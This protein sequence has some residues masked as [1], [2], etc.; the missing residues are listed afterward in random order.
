METDSKEESLSDSEMME[1]FSDFPTGK[2]QVK[3]PKTKKDESL[4]HLLK[5]PVRLK[6]QNK[7][8]KKKEDKPKKPRG[9]PKVWTDEKIAQRKAENKEAAKVRREQKK[10][11]EKLTKISLNQGF[12]EAE[13]FRVARRAIKTKKQ[14]E[15]ELVS[16]RE[17]QQ[18]LDKSLIFTRDECFHIDKFSYYNKEGEI[19]SA[20]ERCSRQKIWQPRDWEK[21]MIQL[22]RESK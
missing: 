22:K 3:D 9:R 2:R 15:E 12:G 13:R 4:D 18:Q 8:R 16:K 21:Y 14:V 6:R 1:I 19:V 11:L 17:Q 5:R 7:K 20:C 10:E